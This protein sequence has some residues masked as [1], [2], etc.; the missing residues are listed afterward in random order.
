MQGGCSGRGNLGGVGFGVWLGD[1]CF[2]Y[3][4]Y[5]FGYCL[6]VFVDLGLVVE[7]GGQVGIDVVVFVG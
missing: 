3:V 7:F 5:Q 1:F 6:Y 4:G 2:D